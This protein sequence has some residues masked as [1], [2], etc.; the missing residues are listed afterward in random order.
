[1]AA[2]K[3]PG[4]L[5]FAM[6]ASDRATLKG[7][8][9]DAGSG[10]F[11]CEDNEIDGS[12]VDISGELKTGDIYFGDFSRVLV[13]RW[14]GLEIMIDPYAKSLSGKIRIIIRSVCDI[15]VRQ[16]EAFV[17]RVAA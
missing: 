14:G 4:L 15:V 10:R 2:Y 16:P 17:K 9:K 7:I 11:I 6:S 3:N 12:K 8:A 1:M 13:G 5:K